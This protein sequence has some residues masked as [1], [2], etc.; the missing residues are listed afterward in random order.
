MLTAPA[1][2]GDKENPT[3]LFWGTSNLRRLFGWQKSVAV[4]GRYVLVPV[5]LGER[6]QTLMR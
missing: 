6:E 5:Y 3:G 1:G 2:E 4:R